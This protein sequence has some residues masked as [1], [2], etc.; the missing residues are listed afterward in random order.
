MVHKRSIQLAIAHED[1]RERQSQLEKRHRF[2]NIVGK[3]EVMQEIYHLLEKVSPTHLPVLLEGE[4][5]TGKELFARAIHFNSA[6]RKGRFISQNC[7]AMTESLLETE[8]FGHTQGAFTGAASDKKG[9]F[10]LADGGTLFLD[11]VDEMSPGMQQKLLRTYQNGEL[12]R[13]GG[14]EI[15]RVNVRFISATNTNLSELVAQKSFREDLYYRL[16]GVRIRLPPLRERKEDIPLLIEHF[17]EKAAQDPAT[18]SDATGEHDRPRREFH[19]TAV[20]ALMA[21]DWPGNVRELQH[22]IERT[23][24]ITQET[25]ILPADILFDPPLTLQ[26]AAKQEDEG[27]E[28]APATFG[29]ETLREARN[30]FEK[31]FL[32]SLLK[33]CGGNVTRAARHCDISRES[34]YRLLRKHQLRG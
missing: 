31:E 15:I 12:R 28:N 2:Q 10:E 29:D 13:V 19:S 16:S 14:K 27:T 26:S 21:E 11:E 17:L 9:L 8:L 23:L 6:Q 4:S 7:G 22:F 25:V 3:S 32:G 18:Q 20:A 30:R 5:G 1:L 33:K 24:L 34:F